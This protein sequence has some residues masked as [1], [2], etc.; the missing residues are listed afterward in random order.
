MQAYFNGISIYHFS[1]STGQLSRIPQ[2]LC[3]G[4]LYPDPEQDC[5]NK[6]TTKS[7]RC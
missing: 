3:S 7:Y 1:K 5:G 2:G 6:G 4:R